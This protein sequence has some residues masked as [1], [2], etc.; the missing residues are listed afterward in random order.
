MVNIIVIDR[1][2]VYRKGLISILADYPD[3]KVIG[4]AANSQEAVESAGDTAPDIAIIDIYLPD[5]EGAEAI[6]FLQ[7]KFPSIKVLILT[8]SEKEDDIFEAIKA[9]AKGYLLKSIAP[10]ELYESICLIAGG[11][12]MV[13]FSDAFR[14]F[15][16]IG[17]INNGYNNSTRN[18]SGCLSAREKEIL[19]LVA[20]G[21]SN[22]E[23]AARCYISETT[24]KAHV[25]SILE[26]LNVKNRAQAVSIATIQGLLDKS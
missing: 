23:I 4:E 14:L 5:G 24:V 15:D 2:M 6:N 7:E 9:G 17:E 16:E 11:N 10:E 26:K 1:Q 8:T 22:K 20:Q 3:F 21:A 18:G 13:A 19:T 12:I 25:G